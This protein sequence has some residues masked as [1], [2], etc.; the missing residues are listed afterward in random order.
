M[1]VKSPFSPRLLL[2]DKI[3]KEAPIPVALDRGA[4]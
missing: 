1:S 4:C 2:M 3:G